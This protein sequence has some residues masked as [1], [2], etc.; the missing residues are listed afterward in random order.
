M[1]ISDD[2][3]I[4]YADGEASTDDRLLVEAAL[5]VDPAV[6][7]RLAAHQ[8]LAD[9]LKAAFAPASEAPVPQTLLDI[10]NKTD[11]QSS[12]PESATPGSTVVSLNQ[13]RAKKVP[14]GSQ[15]MA[16]TAMAA[17]LVVGVMVGSQLPL[18]AGPGLIDRQQNARGA[19][20]AALDGQLASQP[21]KGQAVRVGVS[22]RKAGG[23]VCRT[24]AADSSAGLACREDGRWKVMVAVAQARPSSEFRTAGS[25]TP[26]AVLD[27]M[28]SLIVGEPLDA[29]GEAAARKA[30]WR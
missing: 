5:A 11:P 2:I 18:G 3:L 1:T 15:W 6:A 4:R 13:F 24:Y 25:E 14:A 7:E 8:R 19:L 16:W 28:D 30:G 26:S 23:A 10:L 12:S 20:M 17:T 22:F 27:A 29:A 9:R 21:A